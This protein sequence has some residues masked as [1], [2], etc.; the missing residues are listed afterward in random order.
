MLAPTEYEQQHRNQPAALHT[1]AEEAGMITTPPVSGEPGE[2][3]S[4][5]LAQFAEHCRGT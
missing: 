3:P 4:L 2:A 5:A 1:A